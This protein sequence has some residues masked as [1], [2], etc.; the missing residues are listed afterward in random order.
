MII[1]LSCIQYLWILYSY[2]DICNLLKIQALF[3]YSVNILKFSQY[4]ERL[5]CQYFQFCQYLALVW[6]AN[7][8]NDFSLRYSLKIVKVWKSVNIL[9]YVPAWEDTKKK[10][11]KRESESLLIRKWINYRSNMFR[12]ER[13]CWIDTIHP[14]C[15]ISFW[16]RKCDVSK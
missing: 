9:F 11:Q 7:I 6:L 5:F 15:G 12:R 14:K 10:L 13:N 3:L 1:I 4:L 16:Y 2:I 8:S